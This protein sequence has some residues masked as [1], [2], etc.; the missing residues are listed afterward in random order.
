[1]AAFTVIAEE[2]DMPELVLPD[3]AVVKFAEKLIGSPSVVILVPII[4]PDS[5]IVT[6]ND[7]RLLLVVEELE[8]EQETRSTD[9][10]NTAQIRVVRLLFSIP[11]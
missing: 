10:A 6:G 2:F 7:L 9:S 5:V 3:Q 11:I 1:M 8:P 4:G